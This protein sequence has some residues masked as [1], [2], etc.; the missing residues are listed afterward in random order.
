MLRAAG[1][2]AACLHLT[3]SQLPPAEIPPLI[4]PL[5]QT[6]GWPSVHP[7]GLFPNGTVRLAQRL[8]GHALGDPNAV[9][10]G[11]VSALFTAELKKFQTKAGLENATAGFLNSGT[12][13]ALV[14]AASGPLETRQL[15]LAV[16]DALTANGY[17][18]PLTGTLDGTTRQM[19]EDFNTHRGGA[20]AAAGAATTVD[21]T[22]WHL[23]ATGC[24]SSAP[25]SRGAFWFDAGWP[26]GNMST[27]TLR[28]LHEGGFQFATFEC[29]VEQGSPSAPK[30]TG[31][32]WEGCPG[33]IARAHAAGF[34]KVGAYMFPG[35]NG[36]PA[37]QTGWLLG[38]LTAQK[39][40]FD[41]VMLDVEG[42]DWVQHSTADNR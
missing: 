14:A 37:E 4:P 21:R 36:D 40:R 18:T 3:T 1:L 5:I 32:F 2:L 29:W 6:C 19:L 30:H 35:R 24:N 17:A 13:P 10:D 34:D 27:E 42:A 20:A 38:N 41:A 9:V 31:S 7:G 23:L 25:P 33:N 15:V 8:L 26:Q 39:V 22:T 28:C 12:W 11:E 16:Q